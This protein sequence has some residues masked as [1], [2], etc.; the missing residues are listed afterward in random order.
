MQNLMGCGFYGVLWVL[1]KILNFFFSELRDYWRFLRRGVIGF[2]LYNEDQLLG[3]EE[4]L[5]FVNLNYLYW[6]IYFK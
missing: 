1:E 5:Y 2:D 3:E 4:I 6:V